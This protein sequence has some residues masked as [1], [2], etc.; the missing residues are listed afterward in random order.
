MIR[1]MA[2]LDRALFEAEA[3]RL[4]D[5]PIYVLWHYPPFDLRSRPGACVS[6]FETSKIYAC[7]YGHLHAEGQWSSAVQ[8]T[9]GT[10]RYHCVAADAVGFRPL[11]LSP[12]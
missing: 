12:R 8:G 11:P 9:V 4:K 3:L 10:V 6:Q 5:E 2:A 7:V 1:E